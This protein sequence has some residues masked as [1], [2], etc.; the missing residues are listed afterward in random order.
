MNTVVEALEGNNVK[1]NVEISEADFEPAIDAAFRKIAREV[2]IP[3]FRPGKTPRRILEQR[4]GKEYARSQ[5]LQDSLP[6]FYV[7]AIVDNDVDVISQPELNL[8]GGTESGPITFE[9]I[10]ETRPKIRVPGYDGLQVTIP[11]PAATDEEITAQVD[12][13]RGAF[14]VVA[15]VDRQAF[16]GDTV[17]IDIHG[18]VDGEPV[19][20]LQADDYS[21][22]VGAGSVVPELD[23]ELLGA[24]AGQTLN[25]TAKVPVEDNDD[26]IDFVVSVKSVQERQLPEPTDEWASSTSE[27]TTMAD[28]RGDIAKRMSLVKRVQANVAMRDETVKALIELVDAELPESLVNSEIGRRIDDLSQRLSQQGASIQQYLE[29]TG[30]GEQQLVDEARTSAVDAVKADL[31]LRAVA[32]GEAIEANDDDVTAEIA[33]LADRFSM[34]AAKVRSNL[35]K[36][37]QIGVLKSDIRKAKA[38]TW[39]TEHAT[40]VDPDGKTIDRSLLEV[41]PGE[42][43]ASSDAPQTLGL[44]SNVDVEDDFSDH[45]HSDHDGHSH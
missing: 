37:F 44:E 30:Q 22:E 28:L 1:L 36:S 31:A 35:E 42:F 6:E 23:A 45:D 24:S 10:V 15:T 8:T 12:R 13:M 17:V 40:V 20:G 3:G 27:F 38:L 7:R 9:A 29:A 18:S 5:A 2:R 43:G 11:T 39:L 41:G 33:R 14:A 21:Y 4:V 32:D 34:K 26:V 16:D 25:F 19:P